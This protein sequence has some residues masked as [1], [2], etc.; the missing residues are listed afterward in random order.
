MPWTTLPLITSTPAPYDFPLV[1]RVQ[2]QPIPSGHLTS[3]FDQPW[4]LFV[5]HVFYFIQE[6]VGNQTETVGGTA[7]G[8]DGHEALSLWLSNTLTPATSPHHTNMTNASPHTAPA[9]NP[10]DLDGRGG[11]PCRILAYRAC[12][13]SLC[14]MGRATPGVK[15]ATSLSPLLLRSDAPSGHRFLRALPVDPIVN[16]KA[17]LSSPLTFNESMLVP[18]ASAQSQ[19]SLFFSP[20]LLLVE[21]LPSCA[22]FEFDFAPNPASR[23]FFNWGRR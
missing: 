16:D 4:S 15:C 8:G 13:G 20:L 5:C 1:I 17:V 12:V 7:T 23:V 9:T 3:V 22:K 6:T 18:S 21:Q 19:V 11:E 2:A 10:G 14:D